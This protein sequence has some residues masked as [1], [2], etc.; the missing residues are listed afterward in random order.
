MLGLP[1]KFTEGCHPAQKIDDNRAILQE[2]LD[3]DIKIPWNRTGKQI[4]SMLS[5]RSSTIARVLRP[6]AE[7]GGIVDREDSAVELSRM[8]SD[9]VEAYKELQEWRRST[10]VSL[11]SPL[12]SLRHQS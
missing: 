10:T 4:G 12:P 3:L 5:K 1:S 8:F 2:A 11:P 7:V 9:I 6:Y